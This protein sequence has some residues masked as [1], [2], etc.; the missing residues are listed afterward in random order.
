[1]KLLFWLSFWLLVYIYIGYPLL[2]WA[3]S[4]LFGNSP[5]H[6]DALPSVSLLIPAY[7]EEAHI[8][9]KIKNSLSL[10]YPK[11]KLEIAIASDGSSDQTNAI[12]QHFTSPQV[13]LF[14][15]PKNIGKAAMLSEVVPKLSGEV[16]VFSDAS[17]ELE[18]D[19]LKILVGNF[20]DSKVGCACGL[21]R[22]KGHDIDTR[23]RGEGMY[24][25]YETMIKENESR[26]HS[27]LGAHGAFYAIR[28][29]LFAPI[30]SLTVNDDYIIPMRIVSQGFRAVYEPKACSWE[31]ELA[32]LEG[33]FARRR[34]IA[35]GNCQQI[36]E[37]CSLLNP[38]R[39]WIAFEFFSHK[40][41]RTLAPLFLISMF[42][43]TFWLATPLAAVMFFLQGALYIS[44]LFGYILQKQGK[45]V[46][47]LSATLYFCMG[48][49]AMLAGLI[50]FISNPKKP[51][52][53]RSRIS[54]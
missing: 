42:A 10:D 16:V 17:S 33:E 32:S 35:V 13:K 28:K 7:N 39:G 50:K 23:S 34:R 47:L 1:M 26:L 46:R 37:L 43:S 51:A 44:A 21:Y 22:I 49:L 36:V 9:E 40:V 27:I 20:A 2:V 31:K 4:I 5:V 15:M 18:A 48:N 12:A 25:K 8:E 3:L 6:G 53:E 14:A 52:W 11:E 19:S 29:N 38:L 45:S 30:A 41:L 24:W 54:R